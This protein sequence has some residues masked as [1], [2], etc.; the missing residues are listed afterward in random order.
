[1]SQP[2]F[3]LILFL[4]LFF[5]IFFIQHGG[6]GLGPDE[7]QYWTWSQHLDWGYYSKPPAIAW[8]IWLGCKIFGQNELGVRAGSL[9]IGTLLPLAVYSLARAAHLSR[10]TSAWAGTVIALT[11]MGF[12]ASLLAITDGPMALFWTLG[13]T[14][15]ARTLQQGTS[16]RFELLGLAIAFGALYKWPIYLLWVAPLV[17]GM[18]SWSLLSGMA[19]SLLG[20]LPSLYWNISHD[21][22]TLRHVVAM[23]GGAPN[24]LAFLGAQIGLFS[25]VFFGLWLRTLFAKGTL[26]PRSVRFPA[27]FSSALLIVAFGASFFTKVQGNWVDFVYPPLAV[28][29][30]AYPLIYLHRWL[31]VGI[32]SSLLIVA[33]LLGLPP[34]KKIAFKQNIGWEKLSPALLQAGYNP[35]TDFLFASRYQIASLL[36]FYGPEQKTAHFFNIDQ[37]RHNQF[38][39]WPA[40]LPGQI[41]YFVTDGEN[42]E[43]L[44][45]YFA[46]LTPVGTLSLRAQKKTLT[47]YRAEDF[48][49]ELPL[50]P[51][52]F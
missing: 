17:F 45:P 8:Q 7:A 5:M 27:Y 14:L 29:I 11:P 36:S 39:Y 12:L 47:F 22:A 33:L 42:A 15:I 40:P 52:L 1:M 16:P 35:S 20:L 46:S 26:V 19:I 18:F 50:N 41:G 6:V 49:G 31:T 24:A 34:L 9:L 13:L 48:T 30:C 38:S 10:R 28:A 4:K 3:I 44:Q 25:P 2:F 32:L 23:G 37:I 21:F 51:H 43:A